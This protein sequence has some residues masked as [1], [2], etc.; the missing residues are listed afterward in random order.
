MNLGVD[1]ARKYFLSWQAFV[2]LLGLG[3]IVYSVVH[4]FIPEVENLLTLAPIVRVSAVSIL[5]P[6]VGL[7]GLMLL[8]ALVLRAI[9]AYEKVAIYLV[10]TLTFLILWVCAPLLLFV[11]LLARPL[12]QHYMPKLGYSEC[13]LLHGNPTLWFTD[14][15][16][17]PALCVKGKDREWVFEQAKLAEAAEKNASKVPAVPNTPSVVN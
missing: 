14:W 6:I 10:R 5:S 15:I 9:P 1:A 4:F 2:F 16:K 3:L 8:V 11:V 17:N 12:Q 13:G 7:I